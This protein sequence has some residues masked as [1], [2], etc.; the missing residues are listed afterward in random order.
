MERNKLFWAALFVLL[1]IVDIVLLLWTINSQNN[2]LLF[3]LLGM[4][5]GGIVG[6]QMIW[7]VDERTDEAIDLASRDSIRIFL[8][9]ILGVGVPLL[10]ASY[11]FDIPWEMGAAFIISAIFLA[12]LQL[13][14]AVREESRMR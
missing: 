11:V 7:N 8:V 9:V 14:L 1:G 6:L 3:V 12:Y 13:T 10:G 5:I 2:I 4:V